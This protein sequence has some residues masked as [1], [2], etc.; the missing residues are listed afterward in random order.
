MEIRKITAGLILS[1]LT[2]FL[3]VMVTA[4]IWRIASKFA[5]AQVEIGRAIFRFWNQAV[6]Q[7]VDVEFK[8]SITKVERQAQVCHDVGHRQL[9]YGATHRERVEWLA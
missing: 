1:T 6:N 9:D 3:G 7:V 5:A 2:T 4:I 8:N